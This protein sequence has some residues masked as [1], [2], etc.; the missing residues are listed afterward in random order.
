[1]ADLEQYVKQ[2]ARKLR[3][4]INE[5]DFFEMVRR[6]EKGNPQL[7]RIG[8]APLPEQEPLRFGQAP[9]LSFPS[10]SIA[11]IRTGND[12]Y[13]ALIMTYFFGLLGVN[14][15][16]PLEFTNL[17]FQQSH[18]NY[19]QT[20]RRFLDIIHHRFTT[21]FYRAWALT[22]QSVSYDRPDDDMISNIICSIAGFM[23]DTSVYK[24]STQMTGANFANYFGNTIKNKYALNDILH[25]LLK[26]K[27]DVIDHIVGSYDI[28]SKDLAK[29]GNAST[30]VLGQSLQLGRHY[31]SATREFC[32]NIGPISFRKCENFLPGAEGFD[33]LCD[34]ISSYV[35]K[36]MDYKFNFI[37]KGSEIPKL[38]LGNNKSMKLGRNCWLGCNQFIG[39]S[40]TLTVGASR[41]VKKKHTA[42]FNKK[43]KNTWPN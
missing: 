4:G 36:P 29:L 10:T 32:V 31:M 27:V 5:P 8:Y 6:F 28:P 34:V 9:Y 16:M 1:M 17:I 24:K 12:K 25:N 39:K 26:C 2:V 35:N 33:L 11:E 20:F 18:N 21:L 14:G 40:V 30:A 19:D 7:P 43:G 37:L 13:S 23:P 42:S 22:K 15:P 41:L 38:V 3:Q